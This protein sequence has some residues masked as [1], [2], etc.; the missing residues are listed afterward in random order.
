MEVTCRSYMA[1]R[2]KWGNKAQ[3][4]GVTFRPH[5][6]VAVHG[7]GPLAPHTQV[8]PMSGS[9]EHPPPSKLPGDQAFPVLPGMGRVRAAPA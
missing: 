7:C 9:S 4:P 6:V 5:T 8:V 1:S 3:G 2:E